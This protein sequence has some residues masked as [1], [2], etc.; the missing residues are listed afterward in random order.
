MKRA[1]L[2]L[3]LLALSVPSFIYAKYAEYEWTQY[4]VQEAQ[5]YN[6]V[7]TG[8][9]IDEMGLPVTVEGSESIEV[10]CKVNN[11]NDLYINGIIPGLPDY[12]ATGKLLYDW[13]FESGSKLIA[14]NE[15]NDDLNLWI[16]PAV[17]FRKPDGTYE[18]KSKLNGSFNTGDDGITFYELIN[19]DGIIG[20]DF[21]N[22]EGFAIFTVKDGEMKAFNN[23]MEIS[24]RFIP[25]EEYCYY[26]P[27]NKRITTAELTSLNTKG[28]TSGEDSPENVQGRLIDLVIDNDAIYMS[29]IAGNS[30]N[31]WIKG[32]IEGD[33]VR[34]KNVSP[35]GRTG[36]Y[37]ST[38]SIEKSGDNNILMPVN[39]DL[40]FNYS[41]DGFPYLSDANFGF[42]AT[43]VPEESKNMDD[44]FMNLFWCNVNFDAQIAKFEDIPMTPQEPYN[45]YYNSYIHNYLSFYISNISAEGYVMDPDQLYY[46][47]LLNGEPFTFAGEEFGL[48]GEVSEIPFNAYYLSST[49]IDYGLN[50]FNEYQRV[51]AVPAISGSAEWEIELIYYGGGEKRYSMGSSTMADVD[52]ISIEPRIADNIVYDIFG[53]IVNPDNLTPGLYIK[54]GQKF[55]IR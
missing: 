27:V 24:T 31:K 40:V 29:G 41:A 3:S 8:I 15:D 37:L 44:T 49:S 51:I 34:F 36:L 4:P 55:I 42:M 26:P 33:K 52:Q 54:N 5:L 21:V 22:N 6:H 14:N 7:F 50:T 2:F 9:K 18:I 20:N 53:R 46:R 38:Y 16:F 47:A 23:Y 25:T 32:T 39:E 12:W 48:Q 1:A 28:I 13:Q 43:A 35:F 11:A 30:A 45:I 10:A 17:L 19:G